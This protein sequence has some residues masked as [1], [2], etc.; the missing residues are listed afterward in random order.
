MTDLAALFSLEGRSALVTGAS[1]TFG[2][3]FARVLHA[4]GAR[5]VLA[6]PSVDGIEEAARQLGD[7]ASAV[8]MDV[9]D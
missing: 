4:A 8:L 3:H 6:A 5:V 7:R 1:G 9:T 2:R